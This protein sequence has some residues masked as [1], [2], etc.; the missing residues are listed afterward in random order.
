MF[1][2]AGGG[3]GGYGTPG[4]FWSNPGTPRGRVL[5]PVGSGGHGGSIAGTTSVGGAGGGGVRI[6]VLGDARFMGVID[7]SGGPGERDGAGGGAGGS[8]WVLVAGSL[9]SSGTGLLRANGG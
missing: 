7:V 6:S 3:H 5:R 8:L 9:Y 4:A 1:G 2:A